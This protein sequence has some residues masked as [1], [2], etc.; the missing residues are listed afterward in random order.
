MLN[1][2]T[3]RPSFVRKPTNQKVTEQQI[4]TFQCT[5]SG[6]PTPN[7]AWVKD[8][9]T[10]S[11]GETLRF[12]TERYHSGKYW[13]EAQNGFGSTIR[14][15]AELDVQCKYGRTSHIKFTKSFL[16]L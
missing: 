8:G 7:I 4:V 5:A 1:F 13:C 3:V 10:L 16:S 2:P 6:Y 15:A 9:Q 14:A 12:R 11:T